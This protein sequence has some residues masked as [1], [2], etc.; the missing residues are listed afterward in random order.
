MLNSK[1]FKEEKQEVFCRRMEKII[2]LYFGFVA[3]LM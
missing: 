3:G 2:S 1:I